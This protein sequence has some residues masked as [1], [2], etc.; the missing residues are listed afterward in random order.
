MTVPVEDFEEAC[1][2]WNSTGGLVKVEVND[3]S[4]E[5]LY[6]VE[7]SN[8]PEEFEYKV[9]VQYGHMFI[10]LWDVTWNYVTSQVG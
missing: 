1:R 8:I 6:P 5:Y 10:I 9:K 2:R 4:L 7:G 3:F